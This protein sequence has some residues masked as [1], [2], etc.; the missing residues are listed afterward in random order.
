MAVAV[1]RSAVIGYPMWRRACGRVPH[2]GPGRPDQKTRL[3][4]TDG[5]GGRG[6]I[7]RDRP[8]Q[9]DLRVPRWVAPRYETTKTDQPAS[10]VCFRYNNL[11]YPHPFFRLP[12]ASLDAEPDPAGSDGL[13]VIS[14]ASHCV[15]PLHTHTT[16]GHGSRL[17]VASRTLHA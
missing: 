1:Q 10:T 9:P 6:R 7:R 11:L 3:D 14:Y 17:P 4:R 2:Y 16:N 5:T 13:P 8:D 15:S 12:L